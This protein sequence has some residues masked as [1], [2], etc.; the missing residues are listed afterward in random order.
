MRVVPFLTVKF[1]N[2][3]KDFNDAKAFGIDTKNCYLKKGGHRYGGLEE[4]FDCPLAS[5]PRDRKINI[6]GEKKNVIFCLNFI[7]K[8]SRVKNSSFLR[9]VC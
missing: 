7:F 8:S 1:W 6:F 5:S 9:N 3:S 2:Y 4:W